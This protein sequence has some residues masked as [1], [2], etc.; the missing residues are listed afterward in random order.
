[1]QGFKN[2][3]EINKYCQKN[4]KAM[5]IFKRTSYFNYKISAVFPEACSIFEMLPDNFFNPIFETVV[6]ININK[7]TLDENYENEPTEFLIQSLGINEINLISDEVESYGRCADV[8]IGDSIELIKSFWKYLINR[9]KINEPTTNLMYKWNKNF[10]QY[11]MSNKRSDPR[12]F[13]DLVGLDEHIKKISNDIEDLDKY[14]DHFKKIG[15]SN[16]INYLL[17]GKPGL[18][19]SSLIR[20]ISTELKINIYIANLNDATSESSIR[21]MLSP[22]NDSKGKKIILLEDFDRFLENKELYTKTISAILNATDGIYPS[23]G[24]IRFFT[25]NNVDLIK[26]ISALSSRMKR[27]IL[28]EKPQINV[29]VEYAKKVLMM[30]N[31][32]M[33]KL[34]DSQ[35]N[36]MEKEIDS[37]EKLVSIAWSNDI[38][39]RQLTSYLCQFLNYENRCQKACENI[40]DWIKETKNFMEFVS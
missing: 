11:Q 28:I 14:E 31:V 34:L 21:E 18:G 26:N 16:G 35:E 32:Y 7:K 8:C 36:N 33:K 23:H 3:E 24:T 9:T 1:M 5:S 2:L 37:L 17:Y 6:K 13:N 10:Q 27:K 29:I 40:G 4:K 19:K 20:A 22:G 25:A 15:Q 38:N 39:L 12:Y 30:D